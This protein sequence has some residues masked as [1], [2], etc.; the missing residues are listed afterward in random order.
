MENLTGFIVSVR[1]KS[2]SPVS[3]TIDNEPVVLLPGEEFIGYLQAETQD[4]LESDWTRAHLQKVIL[5]SEKRKLFRYGGSATFASGGIVVSILAKRGSNS[6]PH[7]FDQYE[8][9]N[10]RSTQQIF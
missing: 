1:T 10:Q 8:T 2:N 3:Y 5:M 7:E 9:W 4:S 6:Y